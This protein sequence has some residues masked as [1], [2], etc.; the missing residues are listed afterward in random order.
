MYT[1]HVMVG[2][3][4]LQVLI[5]RDLLSTD[6]LILSHMHKFYIQLVVGLLGVVAGIYAAKSAGTV[7][8]LMRG[9]ASVA[10][11]YTAWFCFGFASVLLGLALYEWMRV[12]GHQKWKRMAWAVALTLVLLPSSWYIIGWFSPAKIDALQSE[13]NRKQRDRLGEKL[14]MGQGEGAFLERE[15]LHGAMLAGVRLKKAKLK[16]ANLRNAMLAGADL[17]KADLEHA[18][19]QGA[20]LLGANLS[21]AN[22]VNANF[23]GAMLLGALLEGARIDG[24]NFK[25]ASVSQE[26]I[27]D[28]CGKPS[29]LSPDLRVPKPC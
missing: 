4:G 22:L 15:D 11:K 19:L 24:A 25:N 7:A 5:H 29:A 2:A 26:Q 13:E 8:W 20:M 14:Q 12:N 17:R 1:A 23:E 16:S 18:D 3:G 27:D 6:K 21:E 10:G 28:A 9:F